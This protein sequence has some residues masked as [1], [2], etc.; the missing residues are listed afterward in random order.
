MVGGISSQLQALLSIVALNLILISVTF[1]VFW[2]GVIVVRLLGRSASFSLSPLG[3]SR[4]RRGVLVGLGVGVGVGVTAV[5][6]GGVVN[7]LTTTVFERLGY[8][9]ESRVQQEFMRSLTGWIGDQPGLAI[10]AIVGVVVIFGPF[11]EELIF[12]G[13]IF[14]GLYRLGLLTS[15][16]IGPGKKRGKLADIASFALAA[17]VSSAF[18]ATLHLEPVLLPSL[19]I[20][21]VALCW[22]FRWSGSLLPSFVAHATFNSFATTLIILSGLGLFEMPV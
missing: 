3:F 4:P 10:P 14:N 19:L 13:A 20:L 8:S 18:F 5:F 21:A 2:I 16:R 11:A 17:L 1:G 22:L 7:L 12:R 15:S 9:T 6:V